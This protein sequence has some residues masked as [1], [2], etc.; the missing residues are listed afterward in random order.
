MSFNVYLLLFLISKI[1]PYTILHIYE[2]EA[3]FINMYKQ[4][5]KLKTF[6]NFLNN[7]F[8]LHKLLIKY[9]EIEN[10]PY[11]FKTIDASN[12]QNELFTILQNNI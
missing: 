4:F 11:I 12:R 3:D 10:T 6:K 9:N 5:I 2:I 8:I 1:T 7:K